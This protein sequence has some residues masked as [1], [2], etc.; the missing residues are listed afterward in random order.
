MKE[1]LS[2][3]PKHN[4]LVRID[5]IYLSYMPPPYQAISPLD[6]QQL[7]TWIL[8]IFDDNQFLSLYTGRGMAISW[9]GVVSLR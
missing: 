5:Q 8:T 4:N 9:M 3:F 6:H 1:R 7:L 2:A